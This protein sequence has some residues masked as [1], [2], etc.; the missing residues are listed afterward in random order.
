MPSV[1]VTA[2]ILKL[3]SAMSSTEVTPSSVIVPPPYPV[4]SMTTPV[5]VFGSSGS[6]TV[7]IL[8]LNSSQEIS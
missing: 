8:A 4:R 7:E 1:T 5:T 3:D 2:G 6:A